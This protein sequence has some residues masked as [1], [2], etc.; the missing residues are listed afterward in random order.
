MNRSPSTGCTS[1]VCGNGLL[2][3]VS[4]LLPN[5][6]FSRNCSSAS[7]RGMKRVDSTS[8]RAAISP[9]SSRARASLVPRSRYRLIWVLLRR[10]P[11]IA[12][13]FFSSR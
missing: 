10:S 3:S 4:M 12:V 8:A 5:P 9:P 11:A 13:T 1:S 2:D 7:S 6:E